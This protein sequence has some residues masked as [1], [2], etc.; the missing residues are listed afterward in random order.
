MDTLLGAKK[1]LNQIRNTFNFSHDRRLALYFL[2][3]I[4][5]DKKKARQFC[6]LLGAWMV[7]CLPFTYFSMAP[8][9]ALS[10]ASDDADPC[11]L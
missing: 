11:E 5:L 3:L 6:H 4:L 9:E 1:A 8:S 10:A 7:S 2:H